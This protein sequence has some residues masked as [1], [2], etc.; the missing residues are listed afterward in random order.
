MAAARNVE[1]TYTVGSCRSY[2]GLPTGSLVLVSF[3]P[4]DLSG[5][6]GT[7]WTVTIGTGA[8]V[9]TT[10]GNPAING[11]IYPGGGC[12]AGSLSCEVEH[13]TYTNDRIINASL[14]L[15]QS[16]RTRT[17]SAQATLHWADSCR[18]C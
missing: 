1:P 7:S 6:Y 11:C 17:I 3:Q 5:S 9:T 2:A 13:K 16:G 8:Q 14:Q 4:Q 15:T 12:T 10:C 18:L